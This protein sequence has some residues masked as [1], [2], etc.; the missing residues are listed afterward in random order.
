[1]INFCST[2][3]SCSVHEIVIIML[4]HN[5]LG[6]MSSLLSSVMYPD[7]VGRMISISS[8]AQS[9]P[10]SIAIRYLQRKCIMTD[11]QWNKGSAYVLYCCCP[12]NSTLVP[13]KFRRLKV[14]SCTVTSPMK[15]W[16]NLKLQNTSIL[17]KIY[18]SVVWNT[19]CTPTGQSPIHF[20]M[21][22]LPCFGVYPI[23]ANQITLWFLCNAGKLAVLVLKP[24]SDSTPQKFR[25]FLVWR[26]KGGVRHC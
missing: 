16:I 7:R 17:G 19:D 11:P 6:G 10:S 12:T 26:S 18:Q 20:G 22:H 13:N 21:I 5:I 14:Y 8:C 9:H 2:P 24:V 15:L 25:L 1:M 4:S 3:A 23:S